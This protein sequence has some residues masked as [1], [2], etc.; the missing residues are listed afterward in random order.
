MTPEAGPSRDGLPPEARH[1]LEELDA[2]GGPVAFE[3]SFKILPGVLL[4][5]RVLAGIRL[6]PPAVGRTARL[7]TL[8]AGL[9]IPEERRIELLDG[10]PEADN[11]LLGFEQG[12]K[13]SLHK[14]YLEFTRRFE[15][16]ATGRRDIAEPFLLHR[17]FKWDPTDPAR[18]T[19][20][21]YTCYPA[22]RPDDMLKRLARD[23]FR[24][25]RRGFGLA[26]DVLDLALEHEL[27]HPFLYMEV[28][29]ESSPR[30]S[31]DINMY[32]ACMKLR[33]LEKILRRMFLS[34]GVGEE[35]LRPILEVY[36]DLTFGH[37]SGGTDRE[38]REF[39]TVYYGDR[40]AFMR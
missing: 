11:L 18:A 25:S 16:I 28:A 12:E 37:L 4:E 9:R 13:G 3:R 27:T 29:E 15:E 20:A 26:C 7:E 1:L 8:L 21:T 31:F 23:H 2:L 19:G 6:A 34:S 22:F 35:R 24:S 32:G 17:G 40:R 10:L 5:G 30:R 36:G 38:G 33:E 39:F 14:A